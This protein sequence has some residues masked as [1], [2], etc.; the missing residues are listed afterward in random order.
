MA[1]ER[2][3]REKVSA[4]RKHTGEN[5]TRLALF[6]SIVDSSDDAIMSK[7][8]D[9]TI[10]SWNRAA[11]HIYGYKA[12]EIVGKPV[13]LLI[14]PSRP[15]EMVTL[16]KDIRDGKRVDHYETLRVRK[17]GTAISVSL[18]V[19]PIHDARGN[20]IGVS[21]IARDITERKRAEER[22][23]HYARGLIE[24]SLNPPAR[25]A[26]GGTDGALNGVVMR[27]FAVAIAALVAL[28]V[29]VGAREGDVVTPAKALKQLSLEQLFQLE[30]TSVSKK[31][32]R[33]S[34]AAAALYVITAEDIRRSGATS[35]PELLRNVPGVEVARVDSRQYAITARGF[36]STT[37]N[38]LLVLIDGRSVYTPLFSG[39]FWDVQ[40]LLIEDI[41]RIEVIRGPGATTWGANAMNGVIDI[42][43]KGAAATQGAV[44]SG[45]GGQG[46]RGFAGARFGTSLGSNLHLR[47]Y[48]KSFDRAASLHP[49]GDDASDRFRM[50][51]GGF[52]LDWD[53]TSA[54]RF[55]VQG[56]LYRGRVGQ[57]NADDVTVAGGN[58]LWRWTHRLGD[59]S[60]VRLRLYYDRTERVIPAIFSEKLDIWDMSFQH[61]LPLGRGH[62][63][64]WAAGY[65]RMRDDVDNSDLLAFLPPRITRGLFNAF[66]Q[67]EVELAALRTRL[68]LGAK[69]EHNDYTGLEYLPSL[70]LAWAPDER[71]TAWAA[72]SRAVRDP[73]RIDRD[74]YV[75]GKPPYTFLAGGPDFVS[76]VLLAYEVGYR[77]EPTPTLNLSCAAFYNDYDRLRS[78]EAGPPPVL[79]NGLE[80]R[81]IG[82][83]LDAVF[84]VQDG[85]RWS[86]GY[87]YLHIELHRKRG[88]T[89]ATSV[90]QEGDSP[91]H[92]FFARSLLGPVHGLELDVG[93]R[94]VDE[95]PH[96]EVPSYWAWDVRLGWRPVAG[97]DLDLV[98]RNL[99]D[100]HHAEFRPPSTR[101]EVR[102]AVYGRVTWRP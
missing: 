3:T 90:L 58:L 95:L 74:F 67:D 88:S 30:V 47:A 38:K 64:V 34:Q 100:P 96:Q 19:S 41:E 99:F 40:D 46:E 57:T 66:V 32:E 53:D 48:G 87:T 82:V 72:V 33:L 23:A 44:I 71:Q 79:A 65:R 73:S 35:I 60:E 55:T 83:E 22:V 11:E 59:K 77:A 26:I 81:S 97:L 15:D 51:Q 91:Q 45:G 76:E 70:R 50:N 78:V 98:A 80:G 42:I 8:L 102:R 75:P 92:Q 37:A 36:N 27:L 16:L 84:Q 39:V 68:T 10:T 29:S 93:V 5:E 7:T 43:T 20:V 52:R 25:S 14:H 17:D 18:T 2:R 49:T 24:A 6:A 4:E 86:A 13:S 54:S 69:I 56:D 94:F 31:P 62:D 85:W 9:G 12:G 1:V 61:R 21:S 63:F 101:L 89:D 28:P